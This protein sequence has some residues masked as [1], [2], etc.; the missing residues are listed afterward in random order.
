[1]DVIEKYRIL[2]LEYFGSSEEQGGGGGGWSANDK[3]AA[4]R[5]NKFQIVFLLENFFSVFAHSGILFHVL[6]TK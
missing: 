3:I 5:Y 1:V 6:Q 4:V 2:I